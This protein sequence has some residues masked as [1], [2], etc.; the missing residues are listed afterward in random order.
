VSLAGAGWILLEPRPGPLGPS[1]TSAV[2]RLLERGFG[3][4][5]AHPARHI[6]S[7]LRERM[8]EL[9]DHGALIQGTAAFL[10]SGNA[11]D[12]MLSL[13]DGGLIHVLGSDAHSSHGGRPL[14]LSEGIAALGE[15]EALRPHLSWIAEK[16]PRAILSGEV[17]VPPYS[18]RG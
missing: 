17:P 2:D 3:A 1:L 9:I 15:L 7:D 4:L 14:R 6:S 11:R 8:E 12:G 18:H 10:V 5:I 16:A 13:A